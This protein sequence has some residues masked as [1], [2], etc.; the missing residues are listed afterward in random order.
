MVAPLI[1][2]ISLKIL[3]L[4]SRDQPVV[5]GR[6]PEMLETNDRLAPRSKGEHLLRT[7]QPASVLLLF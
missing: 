1:L 6:G 4:V 5:R 2:N 3:T 7:H